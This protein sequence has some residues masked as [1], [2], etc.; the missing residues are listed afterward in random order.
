[1]GR[2]PVSCLPPLA[3]PISRPR[4]AGVE[5]TRQTANTTSKFKC[6]A[7]TAS[8][9]AILRATSNLQAVNPASPILISEPI[10]SLLRSPS[11]KSSF[12]RSLSA[13]RNQAVSD[14]NLRVVSSPRATSSPESPCPS[15]PERD[16]L[17]FYDPDPDQDRHASGPRPSAFS[18]GWMWRSWTYSP[19]IA[20]TGVTSVRY[21][22]PRPGGWS[23][24][25]W[26][27]QMN[28]RAL[29]Y[30]RDTAPLAYPHYMT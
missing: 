18:S 4:L 20:W 9:S 26:K 28:R 7:S 6:R 25:I 5:L 12:L 16:L 10:P 2:C 22:P 19:P 11:C 13:S 29:L 3:V 21:F 17:A 8:K 15:G 27:R 30:K 1:M 14:P 23:D 24:V